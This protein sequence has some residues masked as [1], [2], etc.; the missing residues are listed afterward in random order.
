MVGQ[1]VSD[2]VASA[3]PGWA[4]PRPAGAVGPVAARERIQVIDVLR[5]FAL[6]GILL[7]NMELFGRPLAAVQAGLPAFTGPLDRAVAWLITFL[8]EGKFYSLFSFLFGYGLAIQLERAAGG[9]P[10]VPR[11]L[12]RL[13]VLLLIGLA[14]A[15]LFWPGDILVT[16]AVLGVFL[17]PFRAARPATLLIWALGLLLVPLLITLPLVALV[18]LTGAGGAATDAARAAAERATR[19]Y[20]EG[21]F[22]EMTAQRARDLAV[23]YAGAIFAAP[24]IFVMFL[25]GLYA[26]RRGVFRRVEEHL[27]LIR[28]TL[29]WGL[30]LGLPAGAIYATTTELLGRAAPAPAL[31]LATVA[32]AIGA[33]ALCLGYAAG[34]TLLLRREGW[35]RRLAPLA[36]TGRLALSNYLLQTLIATTIFYGYGFGLYGRVG[37]AAGLLLTVAIYLVQVPLSVLWLRHFQFGPA[38]WLWR[39]LT[40]LRPQPLRA[41]RAAATGTP[42]SGG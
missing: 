6:F 40:Y 11:Y 34:F 22:A 8:A 9:G 25:L 5:G 37:P 20:L 2:S 31:L 13:F 29:A 33:P 28:R 42:A 15:L 19:V 26:G 24:S 39:S 1:H 14:H 36:A 41:S 3:G 10:F 30:G 27:P 12:R 17:I 35:R 7:V 32:Q 23:I 38:E 21:S 18:S 4:S 16:Y